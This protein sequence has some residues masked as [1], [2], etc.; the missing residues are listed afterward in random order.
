METIE[1]R[2]AVHRGELEQAYDLWGAVFPEDRS[3]FQERLDYDPAYRM[4]TTWLAL[5]DG[6]PAAAIQI[7]PFRM[8]WGSAELK[9]GGIGSV[10]TRPEFR[11]RGLAQRI[12]RRISE[13]MR[14]QGFD[15]SL[16]M[17]GIH[18][19]YEQAGWHTIPEPALSVSR[20][21]SNE[22]FAL[23]SAY[24]IRPFEGADLERVMRL[25]DDAT[26]GMIGPMVRTP[27]YW[28]GQLAWRAVRPEHFLVAEASGEVAAYLRFKWTAR[29]ELVIGDCCCKPDATDAV[30]ALL[31]R[32]LELAGGAETVRAGLPAGH[33]LQDVLLPAGAAVETATGNMWKALGLART[34]DKI[35]P[36]LARNIRQAG[37]RDVSGMPVSLLITA[38][39]EEALLHLYGETVE[40]VPVTGSVCYNLAVSLSDSEWLELLLNGASALD[41][42]DSLAGH[43]LKALFPGRPYVFWNVDYF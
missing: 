26:A 7:F 5:A 4:E 25:Y 43:Y 37:L 30:R 16:L 31:S 18:S 39:G 1:I 27:G 22:E 12:L 40:A 11:R 13:Y 33:A 36:E 17:T 8:R 6:T 38:G 34:L 23:P 15:L 20:A 10:A 28:K 3:F 14:A 2:Q 32:A 19:F 24:V 42:P 9:V 41:L 29:R 21:S 35:T